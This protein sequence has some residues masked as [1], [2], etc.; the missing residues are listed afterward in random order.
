MSH[1]NVNKKIMK[2]RKILDTNHLVIDKYSIKDT[3][4]G[5]RR[6]KTLW[7]KLKLGSETKTP[8]TI[9][10]IIMLLSVSMKVQSKVIILNES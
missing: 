7:K 2:G 5:I 6:K 10:T 8:Q 3:L 4:T 1:K 9:T